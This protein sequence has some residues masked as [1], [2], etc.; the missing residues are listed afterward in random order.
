MWIIENSGKEDMKTNGPF[1]S[2]YKPLFQSGTRCEAIEMEMIN[3]S[4]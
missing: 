2:C 4:F 1:P 3:D